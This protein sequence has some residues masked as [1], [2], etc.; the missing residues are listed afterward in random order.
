MKVVRQTS[1]CRSIRGDLLTVTG[2]KLKFVGLQRY[3]EYQKTA[4]KWQVVPAITNRCQ[5]KWP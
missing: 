4:K 1:V 3:D 5:M 2:D